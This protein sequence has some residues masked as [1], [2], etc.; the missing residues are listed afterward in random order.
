MAETRFTSQATGGTIA[1]SITRYDALATRDSMAK[2]IEIQKARGKYQP[3]KHVNEEKFPLLTVAEHLEML[4]LG[5]RIA[6]YYRHPSQVHD[7]VQAGATWEQIAD[8][9]ETSTEATRT[10]YRNW[11]EGQHRLYTDIGI[12]MDD[13]AYAQAMRL[14][15]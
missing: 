6:R 5:E 10:A 12:G 7:A 15:A 13:K 9:T 4:A 14:V 2:A 1:D 11:A 3:N 8:A